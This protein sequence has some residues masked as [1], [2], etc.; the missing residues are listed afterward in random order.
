MI[1]GIGNVVQLCR[2]PNSRFARRASTVLPF[3]FRPRCDDDRLEREENS[4]RSVDHLRFTFVPMKFLPVDRSYAELCSL[5]WRSDLSNQPS[6]WFS[7]RI[8]PCA[9]DWSTRLSATQFHCDGFPI[10][11]EDETTVVERENDRDLP[12]ARRSSFACRFAAGRNFLRR[13]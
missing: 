13:V 2:K 9:F 4:I 6:D 10:C 7:I 11:E 5:N 3:S 1:V 12:A 8:S